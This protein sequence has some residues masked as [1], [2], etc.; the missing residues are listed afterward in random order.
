MGD[1]GALVTDDGELAERVRALREH[2]QRRK[3]QHERVGSTARLDT[4]QAVVLL[5][6]LP[7]LESW[8]EE[9]R[10]IAALYGEAL[11]DVGDLVLPPVPGERSGLASLRGPHARPRRARGPP[12]RA[13]R[14]HRPPL[15]E[16]PHLT[17]AYA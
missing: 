16:P 8:N 10:A 2:G 4:M 15:P 9:R 14:S 1:A 13:R 5:R 12:R 3:Y 11:A 6:K 17:G 7:L